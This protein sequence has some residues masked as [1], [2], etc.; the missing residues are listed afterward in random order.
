MKKRAEFR[1][2]L[3][4]RLGMRL[5]Q[6]GGGMKRADLSELLQTR[7]G[8]RLDGVQEGLAKNRKSRRSGSG[9]T[10]GRSGTWKK[11]SSPWS[12]SAL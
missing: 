2:L 9:R 12:I 6:K 8:M 1:E 10:S 11:R 7:F 3:Q 4:T 5:D